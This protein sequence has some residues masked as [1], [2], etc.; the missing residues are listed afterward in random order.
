MGITNFFKKHFFEDDDREE[1]YEYD[2]LLYDSDETKPVEFNKG[3][4]E[5][6]TRR[7]ADKKSKHS[8]EVDVRRN[9]AEEQS[10]LKKEEEKYD[11]LLN[12][13]QQQEV[14]RVLNITD[15]DVR[16]RTL[17][18]VDF[19]NYS[20][21]DVCNYVKSQCEIM[22][23]AVK[24]IDM[25]MEQYTDVAEHFAD[26]EKL[27]A[28]PEVMRKQIEAEAERVDNL[29]VDR[30]IYKSGGNKLSNQT[31]SIMEMYE[32]EIPK[33]I[34]FI[35]SQES[36]FENVQHDLRAVEGEQMALR[37][38]ARS[39]KK[40]QKAI[41]S[42]AIATLICLGI[43]FSIFVMAMVAD[44]SESSMILFTVVTALSAV[45]ALGMIAL[46]NSARRSVMS[47]AIKLNKT[48]NMLNRIKIRY[49]NSINVLDYEYDKFKISN[50]YELSRKYETYL[51]IKE[52]QKNVLE[53][54]AKLGEAE[55]RLM[56]MLKNVGMTDCNI[57]SGQVR[58]LYNHKEMVEIRHEYAM[59]RQK[60]REQ[61]Q[62]NESSIKEAKKNIKV[63]TKKYPDITSDVL[64]IIDKYEKRN[65][66]A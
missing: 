29:T 15:K 24:N 34:E 56:A 58:A 28:A 49:V 35:R 45:L 62:Y 54:T 38:E 30:R 4:H 61:I 36:H 1:F 5:E 19:N 52:E 37:I 23:E 9:A 53:M 60:L 40:R 65:R 41:N 27:E 14:N 55:D 48:T 66:K 51:E 10:H 33:A 3:K 21:D 11:E 7:K 17:E 8:K 26:I 63:V 43:V 59:Q 31:F 42:G 20:K 50:A 13:V 16:L 64:S 57:W 2:E 12:T 47:T 25:A 18:K 39:L 32:Q 22:E 46:L 6:Q 44:D